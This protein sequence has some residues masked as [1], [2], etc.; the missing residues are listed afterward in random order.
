MFHE[1]MYLQIIRK[2]MTD[3]KLFASTSEDTS[4]RDNLT[5]HSLFG[6]LIIFARDSTRRLSL[7]QTYLC[8]QITVFITIHDRREL[9]FGRKYKFSAKHGKFE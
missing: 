3:D 6:R 7:T 8:F 9:V 2:Q 5:F 4:L 1:Y